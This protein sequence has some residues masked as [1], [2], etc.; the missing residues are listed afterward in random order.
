MTKQ[1]RILL[2]PA[3]A[4]IWWVVTKNGAWHRYFR[5]REQAYQEHIE[6]GRRH[7]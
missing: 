6:L 3:R 5:M 4:E 2:E 1:R 7:N